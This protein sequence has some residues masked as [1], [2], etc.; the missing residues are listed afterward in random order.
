MLQGA[1]YVLV[2]GY[3]S[4]AF[5]L[6]YEIESYYQFWTPNL[7]RLY[8]RI[9]RKVKNAIRRIIVKFNDLIAANDC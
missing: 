6:L 3:I 4:S 7:I 1:F 9:K 8:Q 2:F 5:V